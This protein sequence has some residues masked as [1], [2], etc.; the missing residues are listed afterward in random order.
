M[1]YSIKKKLVESIC[2]CLVTI[3]VSCTSERVITLEKHRVFNVDININEPSKMLTLADYRVDSVKSLDL[4]DSLRQIE[5]TKFLVND[6]RIYVMDSKSNRTVFVFNNL[7]QKIFKLGERGRAKNEYQDCPSDFFVDKYKNV[8]IFDHA[9]QKVLMFN[10]YGKINRVV[11][12]IDYFPHSFGLTK[13]NRYAFCIADAIRDK[14][15][16]PALI[17]SD[18]NFANL[19]ELLRVSQAYCFRP[20]EQT[21]FLNGERLS[22]IP[23]LSDSVLVF[24]NDSLDK[25]VRFNFNCNFLREEK[26]E[27]VTDVDKMRFIKNYHGIV[28]LKR[29]QETDNYILLEFIYDSTEKIWF[30][31][32]KNKKHYYCDGLFEGVYPYLQFYLYNNQIVA[33]VDNEN[34]DNLKKMSSHPE[35]IDN[36]KKSPSQIKDL[37]CGKIRTPAIFYISLK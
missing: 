37:I 17:M 6:D 9:G 21:F 19:R 36:L 35:F 16:S 4:P 20:S 27:F 14:E 13:N 8:H 3:L 18:F 23:I 25:I 28:G 29:Y 26:P 1:K 32:K 31:N 11:E 7:G 24:K 30:Y 15:N 34:V 33:F 2:F 22:H 5:F 10:K 12:T